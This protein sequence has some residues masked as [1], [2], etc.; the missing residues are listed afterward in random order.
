MKE[1]NC[2]RFRGAM[3]AEFRLIRD[4]N[5]PL[6]ITNMDKGEPSYMVVISKEQYDMM[7]AGL[8]NKGKL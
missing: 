2:S 4:N 5:E 7:V 1:M 6:L 8:N 3:R